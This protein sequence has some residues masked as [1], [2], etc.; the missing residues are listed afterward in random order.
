MKKIFWVVAMLSL[1][2]CLLFSSCSSD[3]LIRPADSLLA[4]PLYYEE[5]SELVDSFNKNVEGEVSFCNPQ[6]GD[7][8]SAIIVEDIDSDGETEALIFYKNTSDSTVARMHYFDFVD[9]KWISDADFNGYGNG[10]ESIEITDM[11]GDGPSEL[12]I[13]WSASANNIMSVYRTP[14]NRGDYKEISNEVCLITEVVDV[15]GDGKKDLFFIGQSNVSGSSQR[16]AKVMKLSGDSVVLM[17]EVRLDSNISSYTALKTEKASDEEPMRIYVDALKG[18]QQM[19]TELVFW[20]SS[21]SELCAPFFD[22]ETMTNTATLRYEPIGCADI[23]NDGTIDIPVQSR[24]FGRGDSLLTIDTEDI[25]LTEWKDYGEAGFRVVENTLVNYSDGYLI[26][27]DKS[28]INSTGIR[29]Y[30]SQN[31]WVVYKTDESG[32]SLG[33]MYSVLK[34]LSERWNSETF[35]AYIPIVEKDDSVVCVYV[36]SNGKTL[37]IDEEFVKS[38]I[39]KIPS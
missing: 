16:T 14:A 26:K 37:G 25:Y 23:N 1:C 13:I 9:G 15:D 5:Y 35:S 7:Y 3:S 2:S 10:I 30:R 33:E 6:K 36:T 12:I 17:D 39:T 32:E 11:D 20:D 18:E 34:I 27:L 28:E 22:E 31:C 8:R 21:K 4:P 24:I 29:N 19:I 38:K